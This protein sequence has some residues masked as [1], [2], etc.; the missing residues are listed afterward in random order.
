M[1]RAIELSVAFVHSRS[2][3]SLNVA[4]PRASKTPR[5]YQYAFDVVTGLLRELKANAI[6]PKPANAFD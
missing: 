1:P 5:V 6:V 4:G 2:L 3:H